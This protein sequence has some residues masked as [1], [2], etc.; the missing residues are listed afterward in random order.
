MFMKL[1]EEYYWI[2]LV[3]TLIV[4]IV[5]YVKRPE[6]NGKSEPST[7]TKT[8]LFIGIGMV[9]LG[10]FF[11]DKS[12]DFVATASMMPKV[13]IGLF[14]LSGLTS[15]PEFKSAKTLFMEGRVTAALLNIVVSNVTNLWL[16]G[17]G[18]FYHIIFG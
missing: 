9:L 6:D 17:G 3:V 2:W 4:S 15:W 8:S 5:I 1:P 18:V 10:G 7:L 13:G 12:V 14:I 11:L 16:A